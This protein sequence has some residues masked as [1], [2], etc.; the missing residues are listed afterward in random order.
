MVQRKGSCKY[1]YRDSFLLRCMLGH[2][3]PKPCSIAITAAVRP[4]PRYRHF[5][6]NDHTSCKSRCM[7]FSVQYTP[8]RPLM[9]RSH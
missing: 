6:T 5:F 1:A 3:R 7:L 9:S 2:M 8:S 4:S